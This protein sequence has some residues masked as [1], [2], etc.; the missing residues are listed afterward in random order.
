M[1]ERRSRLAALL[2]FAPLMLGIV[3]L[4]PSP[5][6]AAPNELIA[7][8]SG[9]AE[10][11]GPGDPDGIGFAFLVIDPDAGTICPLFI[12]FEEIAVPTAAHI[13]EGGADVAGPVVVDLFADPGSENFIENCLDSLDTALLQDIVDNPA[14]YYVNVHNADFPDGAIR[15]QLAVP[16]PPPDCTPPDLCGDNFDGPGTAVPGDYAFGGFAAA[17]SFTLG[18]PWYSVVIPDGFILL[19]PDTEGEIF[20]GRLEGSV[21]TGACGV[22]AATIPI[23]PQSYLDFFGAHPNVSVA[24]AGE[25]TTL[26]GA[27]GLT[28]EVV[29]TETAGCPDGIALLMQA[30]VDEGLPPE[31]GQYVIADGERIRIW[32]L[33]VMDETIMIAVSDWGAGGFDALMARSQPVLN[34]MAFAL[35]GGEPTPTPSASPTSTPSP[36]ATAAALPD[37]AYRE[38]IEIGVGAFWIVFAGALVLMFVTRRQRGIGR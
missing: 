10:V 33:T 3:L 35:G 13:H 36:T 21:F 11:P 4:A 34:S 38:T 5:A 6:I 18:E 22:D 29:G 26:G 1:P 16:P 8:L 37:T 32:L 19:P 15:G 17:L 25:A 23:T 14:D 2:A 27:S 24:T 30:S 28:L 31:A 12:D 7:E 20:V 9:T